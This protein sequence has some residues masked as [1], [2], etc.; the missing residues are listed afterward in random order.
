MVKEIT[1]NTDS[2]SLH[3]HV[4]FGDSREKVFPN[5]LR[6]RSYIVK[7]LIMLT[8]FPWGYICAELRELATF[9]QIRN[10]FS[11]RISVSASLFVDHTLKSSHLYYIPHKL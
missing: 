5:A 7:I 4:L 3:S 1:Q 6:Q 2:I 9:L 8:D 10:V 11:D